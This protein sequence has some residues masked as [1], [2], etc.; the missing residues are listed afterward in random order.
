MLNLPVVDCCVLTLIVSCIHL[1]GDPSGNEI[2][3]DRR[4]NGGSSRGTSSSNL[5]AYG[6]TPLVRNAGRQSGRQCM[7]GDESVNSSNDSHHQSNFTELGGNPTRTS[8][9]DNQ[10]GGDSTS[11]RNHA[12]SSTRSSGGGSRNS[13][14]HNINLVDRLGGLSVNDEEGKVEEEEAVAPG[15]GVPPAIDVGD[16]DDEAS[17]LSG[18]ETFHTSRSR[19]TTAGGQNR[20][21]NGANTVGGGSRVGGG[22]GHRN[23]SVVSNSQARDVQATGSLAPLSPSRPRRSNANYNGVRN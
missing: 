16:E 3:S 10:R 13:S 8:S 17:F 7:S 23:T 21:G 22:N 20:S 12:S 11:N 1:T 2:S 15:D 19:H 4:G 14:G 9:H 18:E 6:R 5:D